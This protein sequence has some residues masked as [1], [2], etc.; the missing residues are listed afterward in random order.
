[1]KTC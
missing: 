1:V